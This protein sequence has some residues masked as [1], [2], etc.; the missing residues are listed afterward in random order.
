MQFI[1]FK[2][3][4][5]WGEGKITKPKAP[6][7]RKRRRDHSAFEKIRT[8]EMRHRHGERKKLDKK[9][10]KGW[11]SRCPKERAIK[12]IAAPFAR[13]VLQK[14]EVPLTSKK[15]IRSGPVPASAKR[16]SIEGNFELFTLGGPRGRN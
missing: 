1:P 4:R 12:K 6:P 14:R 10:K 8:G 16:K 7:Q 3:T 2:R 15:K 9:K 5:G 11:A 13:R